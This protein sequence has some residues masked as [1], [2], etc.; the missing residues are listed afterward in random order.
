[1]NSITYSECLAQ[2]FSR[3]RFGIK[4]GLDTI[5]GILKN[6]GNPE[7]GFRTVHIAGT[8]GKG[9][10]AS[11]MASVL[12]ASGKSVGLYTSPHL[13]RFNERFVINGQE[14][15][16]NEI[17]EAFLAVDK[18]DTGERKATFFELAT[19]M[20]FYLFAK[21]RVEWAVIE[22]GMGGRLDA[23][24]IIRPEACIISNISMEHSDYLGDTLEKIAIEK[25]GIIKKKTPVVT[26]DSQAIVFHALKKIAEREEARLYLYK[27]HFISRRYPGESRF[28]Y[29]GI[30][31]RWPGIELSLPGNHQ[32]DNAAVALAAL[33]LISSDMAKKP[34]SPILTETIV[35]QGMQST[36]WAGRLEHILE[37][38]LVILDGAHNLHAAENLAKHLKETTR[39]KRLTL[40]LGILSDKPF[41][42]MLGFLA[43]LADRIV[44]TR[45]AIDRS[46]DPEVLLAAARP[47]SQASMTVIENVGDAVVST[48]N[49]SPETDVICIA[50]SL[51][52]VGEAREKILTDIKPGLDIAGH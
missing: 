40:I 51:Y 5:S 26:G 45:A 11:Y 1:M 39:G 27:R 4:L 18:A 47:L 12:K 6:L 31:H 3:G 25:G 9:S 48:L 52:V 15:S 32:I 38:P 36:R 44:F 2:M 20:G 37:K 24:N 50:G 29:D 42:A 43:P 49:S 7:S 33:E 17:M 21:R 22:T 35:R 8:N 28:D 16:D 34:Y 46:L 30:S 19:A 23:T 14:V 13:I 10:I 41:E